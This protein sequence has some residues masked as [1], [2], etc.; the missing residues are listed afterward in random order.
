V[1]PTT[2]SPGR[3]R[4]RPVELLNFGALLLVTAVAFAAR[5]RLAEPSEIFL[6]YGEM[7]AA[8]AVIAFFAARADRLPGWARFLLDFYPAAF[9]PILY[10]T[11]GPVIAAAR[12]GPRDEILIAADRALFG[13]DVTVWLERLVKPALTNF[14]YLSY[15]SY[16]FVALALGI[17][18]YLRSR[19]D[20][21]RFIFTLTVC[22]YVSYA[23]YFVVPALGPRFAL[24]ASHTVPLETTAL[25]ASIARTLNELEHTK[26]DVFPSGHTMIAVTVLLVAFRRARDVFWALLPIA[27]CLILSTVYCRYH[28]VVDV[29]AGTIL[30]VATVPLGDALYER[31]TAGP[32]P[33]DA[34]ARSYIR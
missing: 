30:A 17:V 13:R 28:Y 24:A 21:A 7:A 27:T 14:F 2:G 12:G 32:E 23:G 26:F 25:S 10:E 34:I 11:L 6:R 8:L 33:E 9:I 18:L 31:W 15:T 29:I 3:P 5:G 16:Y 19:R 4:V 22:Y 20:L 1:I